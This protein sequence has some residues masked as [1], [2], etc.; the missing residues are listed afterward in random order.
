MT[1]RKRT[2]IPPSLQR[3][4]NRQCF[5][6]LALDENPT[7]DDFPNRFEIDPNAIVS[8]PETG[9]C[10]AYVQAWVWVDNPDCVLCGEQIEHDPFYDKDGKPHCEDC[11]K[12]TPDAKNK[13]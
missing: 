10:G 9:N 12:E 5:V 11:F 3:E 1:A 2:K 6:Q 7:H 4:H 13:T 8:R